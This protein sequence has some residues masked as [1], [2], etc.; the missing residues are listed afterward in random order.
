M[1]GTVGVAPGTLTMQ[2]GA[3]P[4]DP[5]G[6]YSADVLQAYDH[7]MGFAGAPMRYLD[8]YED[9]AR[10][11]GLRGMTVDTS[12]R[13]RWDLIAGV[14]GGALVIALLTGLVADAIGRR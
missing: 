14:G 13:V 1:P 3:C 7:R 10:L 11:R 12:A 6:W 8:P 4:P 5:I 2:L 9:F